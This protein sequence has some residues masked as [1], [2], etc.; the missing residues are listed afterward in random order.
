[1]GFAF[2]A[3]IISA[4][5]LLAQKF[6]LSELKVD[7]RY[8]NLVVF[9]FLALTAFVWSSAQGTITSF[10]R[11]PLVGYLLLGALVLLAF[12][13]NSL[14]SYALAKEEMPEAELIISFNPIL[15]M[16][17]AFLFFPEERKVVIFVPALIAGASLVWSHWQGQHLKLSRQEKLILLAVVGISVE[18]LVIKE[19]LRFLP[20]EALYALRCAFALPFFGLLALVRPP[21]TTLSLRALVFIALIGVLATVQM[22]SFYRA[23]EIIGI[24]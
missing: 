18:A 20:P 8:F 7:H 6:S 13:W 24:T 4:F 17:L 2:L 16:L 1:M 10:F 3:T 11:L 9:F 21:K 5:T 19:L 12:F 14:F 23:Y 22:V 15:T